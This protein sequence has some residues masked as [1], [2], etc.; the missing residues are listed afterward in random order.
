MGISLVALGESTK[1]ADRALSWALDLWG[2][3]YPNYSRQDWADFYSHSTQA[4]YESWDGDG[5]ELVFI[6]KRG[7]EML[8]TIGLV[9]FDELE[10]FRHL[11]PWIAAFI[12]NP[13]VRGEGVGT[14][15]LA[16]LEEKAMSL[17]IGVLHLWTEDQRS[18][19]SKRGYRLLA[20]SKLGDLNIDVM[21]KILV[22][23]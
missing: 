4:N 20:S 22:A 9:D 14:L 6:A 11:T 3:H 8:G 23:N 21:Q 18:F 15:I 7:E 12:V 16:L 13:E 1:D 19:Y 17:G 10:E 5:Q 2:D